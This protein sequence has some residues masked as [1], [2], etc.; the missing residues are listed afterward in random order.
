MWARGSALAY[1]VANLV[2]LL[3]L[4]LLV[5]GICLL[6]LRLAGA[7]R[8]LPVQALSR[9]L[10]P[11]AVTGLVLLA[12]AGVVMFAADAGPLARSATFR[13]KLILIAAGLANAVLFHALWRR[14]LP[15]WDT[16]APALGR[17]MAA[18]SVA[19][20]LTVAALGRLIAY[21]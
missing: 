8:S 15:T 12:G 6:D 2:H 18:G 16:D 1:P 4:V 20:W 11:V 19:L 21:T 17:A 14:R 5:G 3:G 10:T 13:W 9:V 7:F